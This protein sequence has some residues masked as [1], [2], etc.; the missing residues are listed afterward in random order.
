VILDDWP[1]ST[2]GN[3]D[4]FTTVGGWR[5][6]YG[7]ITYGDRTY[8]AK[9]HEFRKLIDLP[10]HVPQTFELAMEIQR[11]DDQ[12]RQALR[13]H[14]WNLVDPVTVAGSPTAF[15]RYIQESGGEF[16]TAQG[17]YVDMNTGW[18][19]DRTVRY[20]ASGK[21]VVVQDTGLARSLPVGEGLVPFRSPGEAI[22]GL[23]RIHDNYESHRH[24]AR[25]IAE[26]Y[27]DATKVLGAF[28][29]DVGVAP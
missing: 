11:G 14:G 26:A 15:R 9:A 25:G 10:R 29:E 23:H 20:L 1:V 7:S 8:G 19:S 22:E 16:S 24:A 17:I 12:D 27:F 28:I 6:A 2:D 18:F 13:E 5:G 4:R 21:P 3:P